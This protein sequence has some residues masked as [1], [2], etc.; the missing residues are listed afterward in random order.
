M[1]CGVSGILLL[2]YYYRI[3]IYF[4]IQLLKR[5]WLCHMQ[6][7]S[8]SAA[9]VIQAVASHSVTHTSVQ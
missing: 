4:S 8:Q 9:Q 7:S 1:L 6:V 3:I 5:H 2:V